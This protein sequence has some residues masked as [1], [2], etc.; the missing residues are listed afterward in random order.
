MTRN[1]YDYEAVID[2]F[3]R[4]LARTEDAL[5]EARRCREAYRLL[6]SVALEQLHTALEREQRHRHQGARLLDEL[7]RLRGFLIQRDQERAA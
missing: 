6:V 3:A 5:V 4:E 7:R 1:G 2:T